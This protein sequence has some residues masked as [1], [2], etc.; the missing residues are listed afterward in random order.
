MNVDRF[1]FLLS[2]IFSN[3][4]KT[5]SLSDCLEVFARHLSVIYLWFNSTVVKA[6]YL[7]SA[8]LVY[9]ATRHVV[10][11]EGISCAAWVGFRSLMVMV[12]NTAIALILRSFC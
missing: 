7:M 10:L 2:L 3:F 12:V 8:E 9:C 1:L 6:R 5:A 11:F 4:F